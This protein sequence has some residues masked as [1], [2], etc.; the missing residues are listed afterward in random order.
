MLNKIRKLIWAAQTFKN[1]LEFVTSLYIAGKGRALLKMQ[2]GLNIEVRRNRW[3]S[4]IVMEM[5]NACPYVEGISLEPKSTVVD[6]GCY[7]GDFS[8]FVAN[9]YGARV[10]AFEPSPDNYELAKSNIARNNLD[11][12]VQLKQLA[13]GNGSPITLFVRRQGEETHVTFD[14]HPDAEPEQVPSIRLKDALD[15]AQGHID[16]LKIDCEGF[17]YS[18]IESTAIEDLAQVK[19]ISLEYHHID[20]W[21]QKLE[22]IRQKL[23]QAGFVIHQRAP[24]LYCRR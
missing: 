2:S 22:V 3:D 7:I 18:I 16:L 20:G 6:I 24:Y 15:M 23:Q 14:P 21:H 17:E 11:S 4:S 8:I 1:P 19:A 5:F 12:Q 13:L 9:T 10:I